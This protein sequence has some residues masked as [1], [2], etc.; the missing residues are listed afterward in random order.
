MNHICPICGR[1]AP[2]FTDTYDPDERRSMTVPL[3]EEHQRQLVAM[4]MSYIAEGS[5]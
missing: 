2:Y 3:C 4:I 1:P 5:A